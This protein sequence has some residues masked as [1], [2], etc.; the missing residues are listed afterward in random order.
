MQ[1]D[2]KRCLHAIQHELLHSLGFGHEQ[3]RSDRDIYLKINWAELTNPSEYN[4][5][6]VDYNSVKLC[7]S[8]TPV[9][10]RK[11]C[12]LTTVMSLLDYPYDYGSVMHYP[13][14]KGK[15]GLDIIEPTYRM[16]GSK[17]GGRVDLSYW[18]IL[19]VRKVYNCSICVTID[20]RK[21]CV[22][23]FVA[24]GKEYNVCTDINSTKSWCA[25][26]IN[27]ST[28]EI[29][30]RGDCE[31]GCFENG[32]SNDVKQSCGSSKVGDLKKAKYGDH[33]WHVYVQ[34]KNKD[35][36]LCQGILLTPIHV[37]TSAVCVVNR[38]FLKV[39]V[40]CVN[41]GDSNNNCQSKDVIRITPHFGYDNTTLANNL[42]IT[43][44]SNSFKLNDG[45][46][47]VSILFI[48]KM[49]R[50]PHSATCSTPRLPL[51]LTEGTGAPNDNTLFESFNEMK[52][53]PQRIIPGEI[54]NKPI[55]P[56]LAPTYLDPFKVLSKS[57]ISFSLDLEHRTVSIDRLK[58]AFRVRD[59]LSTFKDDSH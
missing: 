32:K 47:P 43:T 5:Y 28:K 35:D 49:N 36:L 50:R 57:D 41:I 58:P 59:I 39:S 21:P 22:F 29:L 3:S 37:L 6:P 1:L 10:E 30:T 24:D 27:E 34:E 42:A 17:I 45:V 44:A 15:N 48:V 25:T 16:P 8:R 7:N 51:S 23:P 11:N 38:C 12:T 2:I 19:K 18:D 14:K 46:I 40:G 55:K 31:P 54:R 4:R 26:K 20:E 13:N 56:S 9:N 53:A 33:P 52:H